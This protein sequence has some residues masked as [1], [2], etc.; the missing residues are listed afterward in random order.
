MVIHS[1]A[2]NG[3]TP[4]HCW[5]ECKMGQLGTVESSVMILLI[6][7]LLLSYGPEIAFLA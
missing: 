5:G 7:K 3:E 2:Q 1:G 6:L 4:D